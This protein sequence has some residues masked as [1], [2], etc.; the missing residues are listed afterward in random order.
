MGR[1]VSYPSNTAAV[2]FRDVSSFGYVMDEDGNVTDEHD[3]WQGQDDWDWFVESI[4]NDATEKWSSFSECDEWVGREDHAILENNFAYIGV[5][6]YCGLAAVWLLPKTE[7]LLNT[8][9]SEDSAMA[10]LSENWCKRIAKNFEKLFGEYVKVAVM[11][12]GE[13]VYK[14]VA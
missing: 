1:S 5:S 10:N 2:C 4:K 7:A 11:S 8:G 14:K 12:N 13:G 6:E 3:E 9:Y